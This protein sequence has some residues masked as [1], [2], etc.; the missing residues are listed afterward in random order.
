MMKKLFQ[1]YFWR[2]VWSAALTI[3]AFVVVQPLTVLSDIPEV[4]RVLPALAVLYWLD[5]SLLIG[6][7]IF[8]PN[9]DLQN[10]SLRAAGEDIGAAIVVTGMRVELLFKLGLLTWVIYAS[11]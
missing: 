10:L 5:Y 11:Q 3:L 2:T 6:R 1:R 8:T 9:L 7:A 4:A